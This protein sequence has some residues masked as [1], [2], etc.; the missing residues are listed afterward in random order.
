MTGFEHRKQHE[1]RIAEPAEA[2]VA[3]ALTP[4]RFGSGIVGAA[5]TPPV[6]A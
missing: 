4:K 3:V 2:V 6:G 1:G 5:T